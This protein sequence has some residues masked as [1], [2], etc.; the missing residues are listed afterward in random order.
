M[1]SLIV[2][3]VSKASANQRAGRAGRVAPGKCFRLY[4][5][6]SFQN[7]LDENTIPEIQRT[8]LGNVVLMLKSLGIDDI[9]H[10]DFMDPPPPE[11]LIRAFEL[12]Y[13]LGALNDEGDLTKL[14]RRMAEFPVDPMLSKAIIQ[15]E[16]YKCVDQVITVCAMLAAGNAIFF[17]PKEKAMHA[18]NAR[19]NFFRPGGDH[20]TLL[21][22]FQQWKET[23]YSSSWCLENFIQVRSMKRARDIKD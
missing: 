13:A 23:E 6:W 3:P 10:F 8:N 15:S 5:A 9:I 18:D 1:E 21:N 20:I 14:G 2:T 4:T 17:R 12:L 22:V 11:T 7:E 16:S 19:K